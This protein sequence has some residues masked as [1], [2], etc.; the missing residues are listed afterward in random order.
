[1]IDVYV[2]NNETGF[3]PWSQLVIL[4]KGKTLMVSPIDPLTIQYAAAPA[5]F[6]FALDLSRSNIVGPFDKDTRIAARVR[7][8]P[9]TISGQIFDC[10]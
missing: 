3:G 7:M 4:P 5:G 8:Q 1:M 2:C 9:Y 10:E 6:E